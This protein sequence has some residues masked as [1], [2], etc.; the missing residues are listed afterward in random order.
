[1]NTSNLKKMADRRFKTRG[2]KKDTLIPGTNDGKSASAGAAV[3]YLVLAL[4]T[5][6]IICDVCLCL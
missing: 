2:L 5:N 4:G 3:W 1:M 6:N